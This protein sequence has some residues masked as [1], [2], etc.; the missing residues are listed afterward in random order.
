MAN[1]CGML[2]SLASISQICYNP[3]MDE[4]VEK[5]K[6]LG[7]NSY[8]AKVYLALLKKY[9]ATGYEISKLADI[10]QARAYDTLKA[11]ENAQVVT[12][13]KNKPVT[14]TPIKPKELTKQ[15]KRKIDATI[16]FLDKKLPNV[17]EDYV[18]P[19]LNVTG[20][21]R[22]TEKIIELIKN[23][24]EEIFLQV[25]AQDYKTIEPYLLD[26]Y[27]RGLEIKIVGCD[28]F[29][30]PFSSI[31]YLSGTNI[32][33]YNKGKR[34]IFLTIDNKEG[35][36][37]KLGSNIKNEDLTMLWTKNE[38]IVFL[39]KSYIVNNMFL[40]D[41]EDNF[42]EQLRYFYGHGLKKLKDKIL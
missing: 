29:M 28:S 42:P 3:F 9:P 15:F 36:F 20:T 2:F 23:A 19:V 12:S 41:I 13:S 11:L 8:E 5:L 38:E 21:H 26:A 4:I 35:L 39:M 33:E 22:I 14:Y 6:Q 7:F 24:R 18:E 40:V 10:P 31:F 37:G 17:K 34:Y 32:L 27:N 16:D 1:F 25:W 30:S